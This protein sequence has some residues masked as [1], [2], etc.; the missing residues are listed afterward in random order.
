MGGTSLVTGGYGRIGRALVDKLL[1]R[2]DTVIVLD[3]RKPDQVPFSV[4]F[5]ETDLSN[6]GELKKY[7]TGVDT[8]FHLAASIDYSATQDELFKRNVLPTINLTYVARGMR[9]KQFVLLSSTAVYGEPED[10]EP[11]TE[12]SP[13]DPYSTYGKSKLDA[14]RAVMQSGVPYTIIRSSQVFG[15]QFKEGYLDV[16]KKLKSEEMKILGE[17]NNII[18]LVHIDDLI[19]ALMFLEGKRTSL[20]EVFNV[21]GG[22]N[23]TQAGFLRLAAKLLAVPDPPRVNP[24][25]ARFAAKLSGKKAKGLDE[26]VDKLTRNRPISIEKLKKPGWEPKVQLEPAMR[27]VID[28]FRLSGSLR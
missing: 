17:G 6:T 26:Y 27:Q 4:K 21:D 23:M 19:S 28:S 7:M 11:L 16:L 5:Y 12:D 15:P 3:K 22:Y 18:P 25:V 9:V 14:E 1:E 13:L 2:G 24:T 20:N 8:V 10:G